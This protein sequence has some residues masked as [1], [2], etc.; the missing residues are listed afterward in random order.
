MLNPLFER[1]V[2][3]GENYKKNVYMILPIRYYIEECVNLTEI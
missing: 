2:I 1:H 3:K